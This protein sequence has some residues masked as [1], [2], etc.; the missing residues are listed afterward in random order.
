[1]SQIPGVVTL[2]KVAAL[3]GS[4]RLLAI[5]GTMN[6][7]F[8]H[9]EHKAE[10]EG[11]GQLGIEAALMIVEPQF[12]STVFKFVQFVSRFDQSCAIAVYSAPGLHRPLHFLTQFSYALSTVITVVLLF[13]P[14]LLV[15]CECQ[16]MIVIGLI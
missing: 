7:G 5:E 11:G 15:G 4:T 12:C 14:A 2:G 8:G 9:I 1:M 10:L 16:Q 13:Q 6:Y 3:M